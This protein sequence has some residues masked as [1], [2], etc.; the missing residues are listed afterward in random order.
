MLCMGRTRPYTLRK[1]ECCTARHLVKFRCFRRVQDEEHEAYD[2]FTVHEWDSVPR[3]IGIEGLDDVGLASPAAERL[4]LQL[5][6]DR[7]VAFHS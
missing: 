3:G 2:S 1:V 4:S 7:L 6:L 5:L